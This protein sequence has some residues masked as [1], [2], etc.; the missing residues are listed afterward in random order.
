MGVCRVG[1]LQVFLGLRVRLPYRNTSAQGTLK[2]NILLGRKNKTTYLLP[3]L[4]YIE[5]VKV[6]IVKIE[7]LQGPSSVC[8][9]SGVVKLFGWVEN[10]TGCMDVTG[11]GE[12]EEMIEN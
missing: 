4:F 9:C 8:V 6:K 5:F 7:K 3:N 11:G 12:K 10:D 1:L 2:N